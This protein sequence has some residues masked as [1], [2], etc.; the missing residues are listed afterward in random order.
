MAVKTKNPYAKPVRKPGRGKAVAMTV[1]VLLV[2]TGGAM[3]LL[4]D[5]GPFTRNPYL[6]SYQVAL[7]A[8]QARALPEIKFSPVTPV[9]R[10][11]M[12]LSQSNGE[13]R[14]NVAV[15]TGRNVPRA[16]TRVDSELRKLIADT[17][18]DT[19][20]LKLDVVN[21]I[22]ETNLPDLNAMLYGEGPANFTY[23]IAFDKDFRTVLLQQEF[24]SIM[25]YGG[26][27]AELDLDVINAYF[28][29]T[30]RPI[31]EKLPTKLWLF[32]CQSWIYENET[33]AVTGLS[34]DPPTYGVR[35][36]DLSADAI[37]P[38][39]SSAGRYLLNHLDDEGKFQYLLYPQ[40]LYESD[41]Y[42]VIRHIGTLWSLC[43][44]AEVTSNPEV[45]DR[46]DLGISWL[47][48]HVVRDPDTATA[49][50][51]DPDTGELKLGASGLA[52]LM[53]ES[54]QRV[55]D[56]DKY[57]GLLVEIAD[58]ILEH[59]LETGQ[60]VHNLDHEFNVVAL[61]SVVYYDGEA[62][63]GLCR[64]YEATRDPKYLDAARKAADY[65]VA[66]DWW[67]Y[68]DHWLAYAMNEMARLFPD[69]LAYYELGLRNVSANFDVLAPSGSANP[70]RLE[71]LMATFELYRRAIKNGIPLP[72]DFDVDRF[73]DILESRA[74]ANMRAYLWPERAIYS[75]SCDEITGAFHS[76]RENTWEIRIDTVQHNIGGYYML[77]KDN[78]ELLPLLR[79]GS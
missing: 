12:F 56:D 8:L 6:K 20:Y 61:S 36:P 19:K 23:G 73:L 79:A 21:E 25:P 34:T 18:L 35:P 39:I 54:Y 65:F 63:F 53:L 32:R 3:L 46:I 68:N 47:D 2:L 52:L 28:S 5:V 49:Y 37:T 17:E 24:E 38:V 77:R 59:Q 67:Q 7:D 45:K 64:A 11:V 51:D 10:H 44:Y 31:L 1:A 72:D 62:L 60:F 27:T 78:E 76:Y 30:R 71:Q 50:I 15:A 9:N 26:S 66:N 13:Y 14:A 75:A 55:F 40:T 48:R 33:D 22:R 57:K 58:G 16:W 42:N 41:A 70:A 69:E 74:K 43:Q 29:A 4:R